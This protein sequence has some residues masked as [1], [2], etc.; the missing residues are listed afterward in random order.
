MLIT[1]Y[2]VSLPVI[3]A[4][5]SIILKQNEVETACSA[6]KS[7]PGGRSPFR[8]AFPVRWSERE[9]EGREKQS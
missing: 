2:A 3:A 9:L 1:V 7:R 8:L 4:L 5:T 6:E